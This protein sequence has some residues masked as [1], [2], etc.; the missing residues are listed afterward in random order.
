MLDNSFIELKVNSQ[1][2]IEN[3]KNMIEEVSDIDF[4]FLFYF[5]PK[6]RK[7]IFFLSNYKF[8]QTNKD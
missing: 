1:N 6:M 3:L 7:I 8:H 2:T 4:F 5:S